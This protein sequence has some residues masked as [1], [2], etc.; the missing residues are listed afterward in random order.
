MGTHRGKGVRGV[1]EMLA[2]VAGVLKS[3]G[4]GTSML[5]NHRGLSK[6]TEMLVVY[7]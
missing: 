2:S 1:T 7:Q 6:N 5:L 3:G 4:E